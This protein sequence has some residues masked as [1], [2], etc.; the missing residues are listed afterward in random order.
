ME[1][2]DDSRLP[3]VVIHSRPKC[4]NMLPDLLI[5]LVF[6]GQEDDGEESDYED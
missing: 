6:L 2:D 5:S 3:M 1:L 4:I